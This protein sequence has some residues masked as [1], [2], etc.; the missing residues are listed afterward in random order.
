MNEGKKFEQDIKDSVPEE[1]FYYRLKDGTA[2]WGGEE[3]RFQSQNACDCIMF[4][5]SHM[6]MLELKSHK[7]KSLP[8]SCIRDNQLSELVQATQKG[9]KAGFIV[10]LR[11]VEKTYYV[12]AVTMQELINTS[13]RKSIPLEFF[14]TQCIKVFGEKKRTRWRYDILNLFYKIEV[15]K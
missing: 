1:V 14:E 10:N 4:Y 5:N 7:G 3:T 2:S 12:D 8:F 11:D 13:E 6:Y 15:R 9:V